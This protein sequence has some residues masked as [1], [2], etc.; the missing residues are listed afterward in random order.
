M[1]GADITNAINFIIANNKSK[2][3]ASGTTTHCSE[4]VRDFWSQLTG[5][6]SALLNGQ[7]NQ[8]ISSLLTSTWDKLSSLDGM[9]DSQLQTAFSNAD[10]SASN[11]RVVIVGWLNPDWT[12]TGDTGHHGHV[13]I[14]VPSAGQ[15]LENSGTWPNLKLPFIAQAGPHIATLGDSVFSKVKLS[16]AFSPARKPKMTIFTSPVL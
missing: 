13:A 8:Q 9:S 12:G 1:T 2:Y 11:G 15:A 14:I 6:S 7:A 16:W 5:T 4:F 10:A 3:V